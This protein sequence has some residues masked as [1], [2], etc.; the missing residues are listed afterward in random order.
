MSSYL[1][2]FAAARYKRACS[3]NRGS[4]ARMLL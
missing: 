1:C 4:G 3:E 2:A